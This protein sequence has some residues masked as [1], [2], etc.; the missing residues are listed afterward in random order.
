M[1]RAIP[2]RK[3]EQQSRVSPDPPDLAPLVYDEMRRLA[4]AMLGKGRDRHTLQATALV[5]EAYLKLARHSQFSGCTREDY[6]RLASRVMRNVLVDYIRAAKSEKRGG[7][8]HRVTLSAINESGSQTCV[9]VLALEEA[10]EELARLSDRKAQLIEL[11]FFGGLSEAEAAAVLQI[12]RTEATRQWRF[13]R[14]WLQNRLR[15]TGAAS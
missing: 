15:D 2:M 13:A 14:A 9:D 5:N 7:G 10:L 11:R 3:A 1:S 6:L 4:G 8:W 12:S